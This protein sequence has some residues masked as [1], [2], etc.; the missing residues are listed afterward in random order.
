VKICWVLLV[1]QTK[2]DAILMFNLLSDDC[3]N[4][5]GLSNC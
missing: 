5:A 1:V 4:Y 2:V 3:S